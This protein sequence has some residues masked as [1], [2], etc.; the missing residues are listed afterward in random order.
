[1][2]YGY[3]AV[4]IGS[5]QVGLAALA[6]ALQFAMRSRSTAEITLD[7]Y[8]GKGTGA[9]RL[10]AGGM[11]ASDAV[12][13]LRSAASNDT[14]QALAFL[15]LESVTAGER[16]KLAELLHGEPWIRQSLDGASS[17]LW[18]KRLSAA[19]T[20]SLVAAERDRA[21]ILSLL[22]DGHPAVQSAGTACLIRYADRELLT[23]VIDGL[24]SASPA[25]RTYQI[26][27]LRQYPEMVGPMLYERIRP[28][29]PH[30]RLYA[31]IHAAAE[32]HDE[33]CMTRVAEL[34]THPHPEVRVAVARVLRSSTGSSAH[35]KLL[36]LL[37]DSDWRVRAQA[38]RGLS[39]VSD[40][41]TVEEL[42]RALTDSNWW[43]R[44]RAGLALAATGTAG[45]Q[46]L[47]VALAQSDRYA[48]DMAMLVIGLS[49]A[50]VAELSEG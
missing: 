9:R 29:A 4:V 47:T 32:L 40:A 37:R 16:E 48:R 23:R 26:G 28:D 24:S 22:S 20:L 6:I 15:G 13:A 27:V 2:S 7:K 43:V 25:V 8:G 50:S 14:P 38:A 41:R 30:H 44:F 36:S 46:A 18:W 49:G 34:S 3:V 1:M 12:Q 10:L 17:M 39:G 21:T 35:V 45:H 33:G 19:R 5:S 31:Y 11:T 42:G